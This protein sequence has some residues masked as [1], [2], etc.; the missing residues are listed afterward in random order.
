[1]GLQMKLRKSKSS[2]LNEGEERLCPK[3]PRCLPKPMWTVVCRS[4]SKSHGDLSFCSPSRFSTFNRQVWIIS[5]SEMYRTLQSPLG[6]KPHSPWGPSH[7]PRPS[8]VVGMGTPPSPF[9]SLRVLHW[10]WVPARPHWPPPS[11]LPSWPWLAPLQTDPGPEPCYKD[12][13][14]C[15]PS[16]RRAG[17]LRT[18]APCCTKASGARGEGKAMS[19]QPQGEAQTP[20]SKPKPHQCGQQTRAWPSPP[21]PGESGR[22][23][24]RARGESLGPSAQGNPCSGLPSVSPSPVRMRQAGEVRAHT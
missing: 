5:G 4:S 8:E 24:T 14:L 13:P 9:L 6:D 17:S 7:D 23:P 3:R 21:D 12:H 16:S 18:S 10:P 20:R 11:D 22:P 1:M 19:Y 15:P 2:F